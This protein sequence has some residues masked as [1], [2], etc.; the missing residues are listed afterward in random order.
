MP[1]ITPSRWLP[2]VVIRV[3]SNLSYTLQRYKKYSK[4]PNILAT[5]FDVFLIYFQK[6]KR[7]ER[8]S[9]P[10]TLYVHFLTFLLSVFD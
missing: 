10:C 5:F 9:L 3:I 7:T 6:I 1:G 8:Y 2:L 4:V